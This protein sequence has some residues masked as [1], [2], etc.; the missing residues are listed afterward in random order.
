MMSAQRDP[1]L[2]AVEG[3]GHRRCLLRQNSGCVSAIHRAI[4]SVT[5]GRLAADE[6]GTLSVAA[7][8]VVRE[9][10]LNPLTT[11]QTPSDSSQAAT[12]SAAGIGEP[13]LKPPNSVAMT[14]QMS[15]G[16]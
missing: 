4:P 15:R 12:R 9:E 11:S 3:R 1:F 7:I 13:S 2:R 8:P 16:A 14:V 6:V 10:G 5:G